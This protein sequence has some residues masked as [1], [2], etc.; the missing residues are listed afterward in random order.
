MFIQ[1]ILG[2]VPYLTVTLGLF[3]FHNAWAAILTYH[4][5]IVVISL[6]SKPAVPLK[7]LVRSTNNKFLLLSVIVGAS[8]GIS[9]YLTWPW[10]SIPADINTYLDSIGLTNTAW[11]YFI[12]Y[13]VL[14]NPLLE[15]YYWRGYLGNKAK[16]PILSDF[17]F[18]GY[19]LIVLAG[20]VGI[21]WLVVVFLVLSGAA[22]YWRQISRVTDGLLTAI[23]SHLT[24]DLTVIL[25]IYY[26]TA[27][28]FH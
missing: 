13:Y 7:Q 1:L 25:A 15:E 20:N 19:H 26:M 14:V 3:A 24:A 2:L 22:W 8:G 16:R 10:L 5:S 23:L 27:V 21:I 28:M 18:A 12:A 6:F 11:P 4:A 17:L 9:L